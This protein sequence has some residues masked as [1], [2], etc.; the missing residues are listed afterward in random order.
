MTSSA[1]DLDYNHKQNKEIQMLSRALF[2]TAV[3][4]G[5]LTQAVDIQQQVEASLTP[6]VYT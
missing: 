3:F 6:D 4:L 2:V 5:A 1:G